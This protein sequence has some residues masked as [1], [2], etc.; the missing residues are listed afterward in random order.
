MSDHAE[1]ASVVARVAWMVD[2]EDYDDFLDHWEADGT[3]EHTTVDGLVVRRQGREIVE[4]LREAYAEPSAKCLHVPSAPVI[5]VDGDDGR[6]RYYIIH[7]LP[8]P[9]A[10][11]V[12]M[13]EC[14]TRLKKGADGRWRIAALREVQVM[15][16]DR[17]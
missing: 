10:R 4:G 3:I 6:A 2:H 11:P 14:D 1:I 17:A 13:E 8:G 9:Q 16:Y 5:D 7:T 12:G 15:A